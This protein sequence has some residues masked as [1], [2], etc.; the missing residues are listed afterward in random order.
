MGIGYDFVNNNNVTNDDTAIHGTLVAGVLGAVGGNGI[1]TCG[2]N[3]KITMIPLQTNYSS[4]QSKATD[5]AEAIEYAQSSIDGDN[6][7]KIINLSSSWREA[8]Y[9]VEM[10]I[11][12]Y[13][14]LIVC[15]AGNEMTNTDEVYHYPGYYGADLPYKSCR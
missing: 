6:P 14:G 4:L 10:A 8:S 15:S 7:I 5:I 12:S 3:W 1:G 2:V 13:S 11:R 9:S